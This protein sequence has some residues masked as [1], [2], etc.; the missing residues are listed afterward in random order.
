MALIQA[1]PQIILESVK[2]MER[3][4]SIKIYQ[5]EGLNGAARG[6][7]SG[8]QIAG[9]NLA[10]QVVNSALRYRGQAP[11]LDALLKEIGLVGGEITGLTSALQSAETSTTETKL[12]SVPDKGGDN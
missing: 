7:D 6:G 8:D 3:I 4:D 10:D 11:L 1:L 9:G 2:P 5:V 12:A